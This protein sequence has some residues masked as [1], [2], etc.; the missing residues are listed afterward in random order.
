MFAV[1]RLVRIEKTT[2]DKV[3]VISKSTFYN[4]LDYSGHE[5]EVGD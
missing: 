2:G 5:R 1:G 3:M 4:A